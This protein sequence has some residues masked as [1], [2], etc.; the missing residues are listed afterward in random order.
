MPTSDYPSGT[1]QKLEQ[2][3]SL[4]RSLGEI[5]SHLETAL[6]RD[7]VDAEN[8]YQSAVD[9]RDDARWLLDIA[10]DVYNKTVEHV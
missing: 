10:L 1:V 7:P 5:L 2:G 9:F 8:A 3:R 6:T 4:L